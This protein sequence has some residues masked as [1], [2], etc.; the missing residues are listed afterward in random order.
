MYKLYQVNIKLVEFSTFFSS[1]V[2]VV[3]DFC[4]S[5]FV[6]GV[7]KV[8]SGSAKQFSQTATLKQF[9]QVLYVLISNKA[10]TK[11]SLSFSSFLFPWLTY[12]SPLI[13]LHTSQL[14][15]LWQLAFFHQL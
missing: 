2:V 11:L 12:P 4:V 8:T 5:T 6:C 14:V 7:W 15:S 10:F 3:L 1:C 9:V 13:L